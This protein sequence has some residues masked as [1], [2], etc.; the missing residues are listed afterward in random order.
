MDRGCVERM[1]NFQNPPLLV[2]Q[3][4]QMVMTLV[5]KRFPSSS[6]GGGGGRNLREPS[7]RLSPGP[8]SGRISSS[9]S[10]AKPVS[11]TGEA[12]T[13]AASF[14]SRSVKRINYVDRSENEQE[15]FPFKAHD[16]G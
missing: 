14:V 15:Q 13:C 12:Q 11:R 8:E 16:P 2:G 4:M 7:A 3:V 6:G 9:S 10:S 1:K 5:G